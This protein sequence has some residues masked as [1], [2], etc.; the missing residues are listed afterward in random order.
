MRSIRLSKSLILSISLHVMFFAAL[1]TTMSLEVKQPPIVINLAKNPGNDKKIV[2]AALI[3]KR[4]VDLANQ[5]RATEA[6][7][8]Q[9]KILEQ[10]RAEEQVRLEAEQAKQAIELAAA[11][12]AQQQ[13]MLEQTKKAQEQAKLDQQVLVKQQLA[14]QQLVKQQAAAKQQQAAAVKAQHD[15]IVAEQQAMLEAEVDKYRAEFAA[16]IEENR[17]LSSVFAGDIRCKL[18]IVLL[19]DGSILNIKVLESSGNVAYDEM[20]TKAVYK[21][22]PFPMPQDKELYKQL[23]EV[24]LSFKNGEQ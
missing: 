13:A 8:Q 24:I 4:A 2:Q 16:A 1:L 17:I 7:L 3:D 18:K 22:A 23:R 10:I 5:R 20:S 11:L 9:E 12:K 14:Q 6:K 15:R 19:P 21:S